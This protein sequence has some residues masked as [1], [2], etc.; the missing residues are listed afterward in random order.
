MFFLQSPR[1]S[2][3]GIQLGSVSGDPDRACKIACQDVSIGY[4]FYVV[5]SKDGWFPTGTSCGSDIERAFCVLGKC[6]EFGQDR[7]PLYAVSNET[8]RDIQQILNRPRSL[9][10][11]HKRELQ[12][13]P[14]TRVAGSIE[15]EYLQELI[16]QVNLTH[17]NPASHNEG[18]IFSDFDIA[19]DH[20]VDVVDTSYLD[21]ISKNGAPSIYT[22]YYC[23]LLFTV[24]VVTS[25]QT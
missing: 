1:L 11:F 4:R 16:Q 3:S 18:G 15:Q 8:M 13:Q 14:P 21:H 17:F 6:L 5:S 9:R 22:N 2:G 10:H 12:V 25:C 19:F 24:L 23:L 20:P 7:T